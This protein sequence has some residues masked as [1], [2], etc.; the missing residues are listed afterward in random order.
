MKLNKLVSFFLLTFF[1]VSAFSAGVEE[2][3]DYGRKTMEL[4][5]E[6][7]F[8]R[9]RYQAQFTKCMAGFDTKPNGKSFYDKGIKGCYF[10][11]RNDHRPAF[12]K[13]LV[14]CVKV[15]CSSF[16]QVMDN[17][18]MNFNT[19]PKIPQHTKFRL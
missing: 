13:N 15:I 14:P 7:R 12:K 16:S 1:S 6:E 4:N 10:Y 5:K 2:V 9:V 8:K 11:H 17:D 3:C 19:K 18:C